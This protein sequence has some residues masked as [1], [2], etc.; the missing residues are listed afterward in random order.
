M[1][2]L[3]CLSEVTLAPF[4]LARISRSRLSC[5]GLVAEPPVRPAPLSRPPPSTVNLPRAGWAAAG[6]TASGTLVPRALLGVGSPTNDTCLGA[7]V[8]LHSLLRSSYSVW[9]SLL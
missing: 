5:S 9:G 6:V 4:A 1:R 7:D 8:T 2:V 3:P